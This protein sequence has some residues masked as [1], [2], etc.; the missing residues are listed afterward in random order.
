MAY[1]FPLFVVVSVVEIALFIVIG[2]NIGLWPT[3]GLVLATA[4]AGSYLVAGQGTSVARRAVAAVRAG[5]FPT[6]ELAHGA[7]VLV[8][9]ALLLTPG[10]L[11]D[12]V[13]LALMVPRVRE[14]VRRYGA[15]R[16][17]N[18]VD[19]IDL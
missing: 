18:R 12:V 1:L 3:L 8:G 2:S 9:G 13:G 15:A 10:F 7:M 19:I 11:T 6:V 5:Q 4:A 14:R 17:R 16:L